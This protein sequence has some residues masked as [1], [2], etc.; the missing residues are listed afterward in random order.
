MLPDP[1]SRLPLSATKHIGYQAD[2]CIFRMGEKTDAVFFVI[3]GEVHLRRYTQNGDLIT[4]HR[5]FSNQYFAEASLFS[6]NYHCDAVTV[7][8]ADLIHIDR[9]KVL[10][11]IKADSD[12]A[13]QVT[14]FLAKQ[15]QDYR[16]LLE[17]RSIRSAKDRVYAGLA[18][19]WMKGN[20]TSFASQ[21]GLT[22]EATYR[23]LSQ[24]V[25]S[26]RVMKL[27]RGKYQIA[28]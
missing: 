8:N 4:I 28:L 18:E 22:H 1:F 11:L 15:V 14:S 2:E 26:K 23:A 21:I 24:L 27:G 17:L 16:R 12:F 6:D 19:G 10:E 20:I 7:Q 3:R 5:A 9:F 25:R 13:L